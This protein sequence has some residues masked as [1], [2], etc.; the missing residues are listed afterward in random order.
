M[1]ADDARIW[2]NFTVA[3]KV[4]HLTNVLAMGACSCG[5]YGFSSQ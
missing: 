5:F 2:S 4:A 1:A 3:E